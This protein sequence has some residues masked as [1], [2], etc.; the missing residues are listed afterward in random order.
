MSTNV[1]WW[2]I[3]YM[4]DVKCSKMLPIFGV[5]SVQVLLCG[6]VKKKSAPLMS[7]K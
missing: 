2:N 6:V 4:L 7:T 5:N 1:Q 3:E